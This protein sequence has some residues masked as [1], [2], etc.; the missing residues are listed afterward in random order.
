MRY[1]FYIL[2]VFV[3]TSCA[4]RKQQLDNNDSTIIVVED[5]IYEIDNALTEAKQAE[6]RILPTDESIN[7]KSLVE[8]ISDLK[9][10]V[11]KKETT[12]LFDMLD[13]N[14]TVSYGG[15]IYG[16]E[17]FSKH[18]KL[19]SP[20][21][22][23]LWNVFDKLLKMGGTWEKD[24][25]G[26]DYFCIPYIHSNKTFSKY[27]YDFDW[28]FTAVCVTPIVK[29]YSKPITNST[30]VAT[31]S[32]DIVEIDSDFIHNDFTKIQTIDKRIHG[33]VQTLKIM[34]L[35]EEH[36]VIEKRE[37]NWKITSFAPYD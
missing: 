34:N 3:L 31:L 5:R 28:P 23:E 33:Y 26:A 30:E 13:P 25:N 2:C 12:S 36:I 16:I 18:W 14:I 24:E 8:F 22:S 6:Y 10:I 37:N 17:E 1:L 9:E 7:D 11:S 35:A 4:N 32:Y 27:D 19:N 20:E 15:G 29:V 21:E